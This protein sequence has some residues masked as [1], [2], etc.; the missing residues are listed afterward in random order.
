M[1]KILRLAA[2]RHKPIFS[3]SSN[4][5][6]EGWKS[7]AFLI[8]LWPVRYGGKKK[9]LVICPNAHPGEVNEL[10]QQIIVLTIT[11]RRHI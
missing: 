10:F 2:D 4:M 3:F 6:F 7:L 11:N 5:C 8:K 1:T 9:L